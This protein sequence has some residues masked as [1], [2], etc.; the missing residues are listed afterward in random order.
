MAEVIRRYVSFL[1]KLV[2]HFPLSKWRAC[3]E[4]SVVVRCVPTRSSVKTLLCH[5][6]KRNN[7][8][9]TTRHFRTTRLMD[10]YD[11]SCTVRVAAGNPCVADL[12]RSGGGVWTLGRTRGMLLVGLNNSN[13][14]FAT[15]L[16]HAHLPHF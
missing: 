8:V 5:T 1:L 15:S 7:H 14:S 12:V 2:W 11:L 4:F 16:A 9:Y 6:R 13:S 10:L 3:P